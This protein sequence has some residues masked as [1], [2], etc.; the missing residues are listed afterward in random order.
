MYGGDIIACQLFSEPAAGSD[1]AAVETR[2]VRDG[3]TLGAQRAEGVDVDRPARGHRHGAVP[4]ESRQ[5]QAQGHHGLPGRHEG[6]RRRGPAAAPDERGRGVQRG[7]PDRRRRPRRPPTRRG[8]RRL[9]GRADHADERAGHRGREAVRAGGRRALPAVPRRPA[10]RP[11][12]AC[13]TGRCVA[14]SPSC[15][16][17]QTATEYLNRQAQRRLRAGEHP[18]PEASVSKLMYAQN[19]TRGAHFAAEVVG[20]GSSPTPAR[21]APSPGRSC[22]CPCRRC[23]SSAEPRR[24]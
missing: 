2:A 5:A 7:V 11:T 6:S 4:H 16:A 8:G 15:Y 9:A 24:S 14:S 23:A 17:V 13:T 21:G 3:D 12:G 10:A 18:G 1:L 20:P 22:C 19:L